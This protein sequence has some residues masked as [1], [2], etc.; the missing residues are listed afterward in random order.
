MLENSSEPN[1]STSPKWGNTTK[2]IVGLTLVAIFAGLLINFKVFIGPLILAFMLAY[3]LYPFAQT[4]RKY[5]KLP[6][7][8]I[9][10]LIFLVFI[11]ISV[12]LL[13]WGGVTLFIQIQSLITFLQG[14]INNIPTFINDLISKPFMLGPF[15]LDIARI[16]LQGLS[17]QIIGFV[18]SLL[19]QAG[20]MLGSLASG[21]ASTI[22]WVFFIL[23]VTYFM[24]L[25]AK[26]TPEGLINLQIPGYNEDIKRIEAEL[27]KIWNAFMRGQF[28]IILLAFCVYTI[29]LGALGMN[30]Y[31]GL[32]LLAGMARLVPYAGPSI[33]WTTLGLVAYFQG[34]T[35]FGLDSGWFAIMMVALAFVTDN[36]FD[37]FITPRIMSNTLSVHPAAVL[38]VALMGFSWMGIIGLIMAA[39]VLATIKLFYEYAVRKLFDAD[40]WEGFKESEPPPPLPKVVQKIF[41]RANSKK[42]LDKNA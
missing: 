9:I 36:I 19:G 22:W 39:P 20:T 35:A 3:L 17:N 37:S 1:V 23:W 24:L 14:A 21:A 27:G 33:S 10:N 5:T 34:T 11:L 25:E 18:Q 32:A 42:A 4:V 13:V 40:P 2:L 16:D 29:L 15:T 26:G 28:T 12:S 41:E 38:V 8:L 30:Y 7:G 6:W 31:I